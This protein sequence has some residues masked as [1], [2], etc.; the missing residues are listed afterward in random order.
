MERPIRSNDLGDM[1]PDIPAVQISSKTDRLSCKDSLGILSSFL[2]K[3]MNTKVEDNFVLDT[4][5]ALFGVQTCDI[6]R[7]KGRLRNRKIWVRL[8]L[9]KPSLLLSQ[10]RSRAR[11]VRS[12]PEASQGHEYNPLGVQEGFYS[13]FTATR[14]RRRRLD[15][16]GSTHQPSSTSEVSTPCL[17]LQC[18]TLWGKFLVCP[19]GLKGD[20]E[21]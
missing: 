21:L 7:R 16:Q 11:Q 20:F 9:W 14:S 19:W 1:A 5:F 4:E 6:W 8:I 3:P 18:V 10:G 13:S 2:R 12:C 17:A 15:R